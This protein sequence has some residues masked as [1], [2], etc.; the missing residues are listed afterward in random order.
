MQCVNCQFH[1]MPGLTVCGRCGSSLVLGDAISVYPPRASAWQQAIRQFIDYPFRRLWF[2]LRSGI[3]RTGG[4]VA[5]Q[6]SVDLDVDLPTRSVLLRSVIPGLAHVAAGYTTRGRI[7]CWLYL[8]LGLSGVFFFGT[9]LGSILLG[10]AF[11]VHV[12]SVIDLLGGRGSPRQ[13]IEIAFL[14]ICAV[15]LMFYAP[16]GWLMSH[17]ASARAINQDMDLLRRGD[18]VLVN[19]WDRAEPGQLV[20]FWL[21]RDLREPGG[22]EGY[23]HVVYRIPAGERVARVVAEP[24]QRVEWDGKELRVD[25]QAMDMTKLRIRPNWL[26][27]ENP[28]VVPADR[29]FLQPVDVPDMDSRLHSDLWRAASLARVEDIRGS[30]YMVYQPL[31]R[32]T[33]LR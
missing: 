6:L 18:V 21:D 16:V 13:R 23:R 12:S 11:S 14:T 27:P 3:A 8:I 28:Y 24:G 2:G 9:T 26:P 32:R 15:A 22:Q 25:G 7:F 17:V 30:I 5:K 20:L 29:Y 19:R 33:L 4:T 31:R 10:L 1:N